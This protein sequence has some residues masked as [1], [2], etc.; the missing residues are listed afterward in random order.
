MG[1]FKKI[2]SQMPQMP[3]AG[4]QP[5]PPPGTIGVSG[6]GAVDPAL[7]GGPSTQPLAV[8]DPM[9]API[10]GVSLERYA[11]I[12][13]AAANRGVTDEAG[14]CAVAETMGVSGDAYRQAM[15]GWNDR[16][17]QSMVVGQQF[18]R[19]YMAS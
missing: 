19:T 16:M 12:T 18:N 1:L 4:Q 6:A 8:D 3:T 9:L 2:S 15:Q 17:K 5:P 10:A 13:K 7:F 14:V 11:Q